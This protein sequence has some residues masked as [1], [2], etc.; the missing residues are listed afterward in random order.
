[1]EATAI[2]HVNLR[3]PEGELESVLEFYGEQLGFEPELIGYDANGEPYVDHPS[4][5]SVRLND[6][7]LIHLTPAENPDVVNR[8]GDERRTGFDHVSIVIDEP[9]ETIKRRLD[10]AGVRIREEFEPGGATGVAPAVFVVDPAGYVIEL[11]ENPERR[12]ERNDAIWERYREDGDV[13]GIAD[14]FGVDTR[15]VERVVSYRNGGGD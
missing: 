6:D 7:C 2:D 3:Y 13:A 11:K 10:E 12:R 14:E 1:M 15:V 5:F 9:I 8:Y 4:H